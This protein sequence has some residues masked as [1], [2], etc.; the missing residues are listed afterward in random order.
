MLKAYLQRRKLRRQIKQRRLEM[1][2]AT[3][4]LMMVA[5]N[6]PTLTSPVHNLVALWRDTWK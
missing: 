2:L 3:M 6:D 4:D 5:I 1:R